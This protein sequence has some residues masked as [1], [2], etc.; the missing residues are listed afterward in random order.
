MKRITNGSVLKPRQTTFDE[1][2][3][4]T[5]ENYREKIV[6]LENKISEQA[7][8]ID[9]L[10]ILI[11]N[12]PEPTYV[13]AYKVVLPD[14][15]ICTYTGYMISVERSGKGIMTY[16]N[17]DVFEGEWIKNKMDGQITIRY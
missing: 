12:G 3:D 8:K 16:P 7:K 5:G 14:N 13:E 4:K 6:E 15:T 11:S 10:T 9:D 17:G 1:I 2:I